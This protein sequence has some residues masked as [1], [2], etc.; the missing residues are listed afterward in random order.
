M[1]VMKIKFTAGWNINAGEHNVLV[2]IQRFKQM[3]LTAS[4]GTSKL[5]AEISFIWA[6]VT[7]VTRNYSEKFD[8]TQFQQQVLTR[9]RLLQGRPTTVSAHAQSFVQQSDLA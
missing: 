4:D 2:R 9:H 3:H 8:W 7:D 6:Y 5:A 1:N